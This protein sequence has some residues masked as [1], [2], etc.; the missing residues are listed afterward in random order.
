MDKTFVNG[1]IVKKDDKAPAWVKMKLSLK[2]KDFAEFIKEHKDG[3]WM[4]IVISESKDGKLYAT[5]D[6]WK[7]DKSKSKT[8]KDDLPF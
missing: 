5:L 3:E 6:T 7:P 8:N 1:M 4:N 2:L